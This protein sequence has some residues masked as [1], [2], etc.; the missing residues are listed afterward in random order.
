MISHT[1][2]SLGDT[3]EKSDCTELMQKMTPK[4]SCLT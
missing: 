4:M 3:S 2:R 1:S